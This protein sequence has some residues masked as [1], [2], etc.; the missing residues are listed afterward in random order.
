MDGQPE[1][2]SGLL[3]LRELALDLHWSWNHASDRLWRELDAE[4]WETT[5]NPWGVLHT[6]S[7]S[8]TRALLAQSDFRQTIEALLKEKRE[9]ANESRWFQQAHP[10]SPLKTVAYFS[11]E[12]MLTEALPIYSGGLGNVAGDQLKTASDLGVPVVGVGLLYSQGYFR[13]SI[14]R[15][16]SQEALY[17][18]NE[19][20]QLPIQPLRSADGEWLRL[21]ID[22]PGCKL[23]IRTWE[24]QIGRL[25]LYL[26]DMNDP[27]NPATYRCITSELYGGG[28]ETRLMQEMI[29]GMAGW[30]LLRTL[31]LEPQVCHLNEGHAAFAALERIRCFRVDHD[32]S[33]AEALAATRVGNVFTT[34]TAVAA[35]F[36][37]F[38]PELITKYFR[39]YAENHLG[40][41]IADFLALGRKDRNDDLEPFNMAYLAIRSSGAVN[42]VSALHGKVSRSL[43]QPLFPGWPTDDVPIGHVTNGIHVPTWD[44]VQSDAL[45][46]EAA[47]KDRWRGDLTGLETGILKLDIQQIWR[48]RNESRQNLCDRVRRQYLRQR[49]ED[50]EIG[51]GLDAA[52][53]IFDPH[54]L[55]L[56][57]AR[58]FATYKRPALLLRDPDRLVRILTDARHPVQLVLA[59]K[60][61]PQD[62]EGQ[63]L[64]KAWNEF[65]RR[66][67]L[68]S[69]L[70][71]VR[72]YNMRQ[73]E[74]LVQG[75]DLWINTPRRPWEASGT[76]GMKILANGGL[77]LSELDGWWAEAYEPEVG[78][79]IGDG[80][81]HGDDP[82]VDEAEADA[83]YSLLEDVIVPEFYSR[84]QDGIPTRWIE[85][86]RES[87]ASLA[88]RFST[89]RTVREY[90]EKFYLPAAVAYEA[91]SAE[92]GKVAREL[93]RWKQDLDRL[94]PHVRF[95]AV[96]TE[97]AEDTRL[98]SVEVYLGELPPEMVKV[99]LYAEPMAGEKAFLAVMTGQDSGQ[100]S[101]RYRASIPPNR[102][103]SD[104]TPRIVPY[105]P[106]ARLPLE[107]T[108]IAWQR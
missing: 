15:D 77:N 50:A 6:V 22:L 21:Q 42:A 107:D 66:P 4:T 14:G 2:T 47:G 1:E 36:D 10:A 81:E 12:F 28:P 56:G 108:R 29:L 71:F 34:H 92:G 89:N 3:A 87:M 61:H 51:G 75:V 7:R 11:L 35:G 88:P 76:S 39:S 84:N 94:W 38:A 48:M 30:Q 37:R 49:V 5:G 100:G 93:A 16:G 13:Q 63:A 27:A 25:K 18:V 95:G 68:R 72:D 53:G 78:W 79:A 86:V 46:T 8:K 26:L 45:W 96:N 69:R 40:I 23:W 20:D 55:T 17:P 73:A 59:G 85:R 19:P 41:A 24:V 43:F 83:L 70:I 105:H 62:A 65:A 74:W 54:A 52:H 82:T 57:F 104:F 58:R 90:A 97:E 9:A 44:S 98:F 31:G 33:F 32:V 60:A 101:Y 80:E 106:L 64:I 103:V 91:R 102:P 99:E 67:E